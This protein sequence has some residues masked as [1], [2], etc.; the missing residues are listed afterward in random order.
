MHR[1]GKDWHS[2]FKTFLFSI[3]PESAP[4]SFDQPDSTLSWGH[5]VHVSLRP[6]AQ[7]S[8]DRLSCRLQ[9][10]NSPHGLFNMLKVLQQSH[11]HLVKQEL[12]HGSKTGTQGKVL[13]QRSGSPR[14]SSQTH[15]A[16]S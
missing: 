2:F 13:P 11:P 14:S 15:P 10:L 6:D 4:T 9:H 8:S 1:L 16:V 7:R 3:L 5:A 12:E